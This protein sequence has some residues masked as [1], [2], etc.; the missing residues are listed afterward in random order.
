MHPSCPFDGSH[1]VEGTCLE[2]GTAPRGGAQGDHRAGSTVG[3]SPVPSVAGPA[4]HP[5]ARNSPVSMFIHPYAGRRA[6]LVGAAALTAVL[7]PAASAAAHPESRPTSPRPSRRTSASPSLRGRVRRGRLDRT[8]RRAARGHRSPCRD[9]RRGAQGLEAQGHR[10]RLHRR[11]PGQGDRGRRRTRSRSGSCR[12]PRMS[13]SR[14][15]RPTATGR[16]RAGSNCP[17]AAGNPNSP[18]RFRS[19]GDRPAPDEPR[20]PGGGTQ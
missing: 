6:G 9:A 12:T 5:P 15:S 17:A 11:R 8:A 14:P 10:R 3:P 1:A 19:H 13:R 16:L 4:L 18:R 2:G 7:G 20:R